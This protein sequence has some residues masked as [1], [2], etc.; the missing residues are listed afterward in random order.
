LFEGF[1]SV[2]SNETEDNLNYYKTE[3]RL[4]NSYQFSTCFS[5]L[6]CIEFP[7]PLQAV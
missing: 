4:H 5:S 3:Y 6:Y 7:D 2:L 1:S